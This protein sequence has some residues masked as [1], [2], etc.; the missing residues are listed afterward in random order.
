MGGRSFHNYGLAVDFALLMP[1]G[2]NV[3]W[4]TVRDGNKNGH[5]DWF[6]VASIGKKPGFERGGDWERFIDMPHFQMTF[7][8]TIDQCQRGILPPDK[9]I[10]KPV[11]VKVTVN[12]KPVPDGELI[13]GVTFVP[14]RVVGEALGAAIGW[15]NGAKKPTVQGIMVREAVTRDNLAN[16]PIRSVSEKLGAAVVW[17]SAAHRGDHL[18]EVSC[19][20]L[21]EIPSGCQQE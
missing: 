18:E 10:T 16:V 12:G 5:R 19:F 13:E 3:S 2:K 21:S 6:E 20:A 15:D 8:V 11:S 9:P 17:D 1:D 7:G 14:V 4:D